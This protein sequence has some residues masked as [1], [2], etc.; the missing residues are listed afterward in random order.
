M[1]LE[2]Y[3]IDELNELKEEIDKLLI[4]KKTHIYTYECIDEL[5]KISENVVKYIQKNIN[6]LDCDTL[7]IKYSADS[8]E[9]LFDTLK[10]KFLRSGRGWYLHLFSS[11]NGFRKFYRIGKKLYF[12]ENNNKIEQPIQYYDLNELE[13]Q[14][15]S[16]LSI[17]I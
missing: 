8:F 1:N 9:V 4:S 10:I 7:R 16:L 17:Y 6:Y 15:Y 14:I 3:T 5:Q 12:E 13:R 11:N 2:I